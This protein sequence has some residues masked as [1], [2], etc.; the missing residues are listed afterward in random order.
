MQKDKDLIEKVQ[1]R[2]TRMTSG[3]KGL[4]YE[5]R[6]EK[7]KLTTLETRRTRADLLQVYK[8]VNGIDGLKLENFFE[9]GQK[10]RTRGHSLRFFKKRFKTTLGSYSFGNRVVNDWNRLP[11]KIVKAANVNEFK[12]LIENHLGHTSGLR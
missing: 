11:D 6:L 5:E 8:I 2:A 9:I 1:R 10:A 7:L 12:R 4:T 3:F